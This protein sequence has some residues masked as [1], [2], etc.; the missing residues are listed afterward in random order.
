MN[1]TKIT[2]GGMC[3]GFGMIHLN[4]AMMLA[5]FTCDADVELTLWQRMLNRAVETSFN[6]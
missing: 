6:S 3:K 1:G 2:V 4:M 5:V